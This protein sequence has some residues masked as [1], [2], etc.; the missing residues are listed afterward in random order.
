MGA[1]GAA[2]EEDPELGNGGAG[3]PLGAK[4]G[5][6]GPRSSRGGLRT[7]LRCGRCSGAAGMGTG[8]ACGSRLGMRSEGLA[9]GEQEHSWTATKCRADSAFQ[10]L[11]CC[12]IYSV[13]NVLDALVAISEAVLTF[14]A[15]LGG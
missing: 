8:M 4:A 2:V 7:P 12:C 14:T 6:E 1:A 9:V 13:W 11:F 15:C 10:R 5:A 3:K